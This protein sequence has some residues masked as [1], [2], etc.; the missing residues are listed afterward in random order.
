MKIEEGKLTNPG[1]SAWQVN[2]A[3]TAGQL[4]TYNGKT[5]KCLQ[6]HTSL[7]GWE[8]SNVPALW[9]LQN[10]G[11][12][13]LEL[14]ES[15]AISGDSL[16]SLASTGKRVSIKDL[17]DEKDFEIWAINEQTMKL[18][19]A[20]VSR[21]FCT[22]KKLVYILKTRLGRTIKATANHRFLTID[23]W[24]RLDELSLKEHIA[25]PRK[26]ESSSLQLSPEIEKLSQSDIYWDSIVSITET[27]V[28]EVFD[29]TVPGPHNF[30]AND[31]IVHN[32][33]QYAPGDEP[34]YDEDTDDSDKLVENDTSITDEDYAAIEASLS[35]TFNTAADPGRRLGEGSKP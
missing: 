24:K 19:S 7:A 12:N 16:I 4:V 10:N 6:P 20:K 15:G 21:V 1:V 5:Y 32:A 26:L 27:G 28:E 29:L 9:Q 25:L 35:E 33:P 18:E 22:G 30:V 13:G 34:S 17:L 2:T 3:Y 8:P 14:R 31:I 23:G 11:N